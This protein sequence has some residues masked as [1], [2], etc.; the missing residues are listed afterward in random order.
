MGTSN[1]KQS[2]EGKLKAMG[3]SI[4]ALYPLVL[5]GANNGNT[6]LTLDYISSSKQLVI[7]YGGVRQGSIT[8]S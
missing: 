3:V 7:Y 1:I 5:N 4:N 2:T 8:V 6:N